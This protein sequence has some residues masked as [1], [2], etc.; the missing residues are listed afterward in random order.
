MKY[1]LLILLLI[2]PFFNVKAEEIITVSSKTTLDK[3][4]ITSS[5]SNKSSLYVTNGDLTLT[6]S[7]V[8][9]DG[10][11][12]VDGLSNK[13]NSAII[14]SPKSLFTMNKSEVETKALYAHGIYFEN[15]SENVLKSSK[16]YTNNKYSSGIVNDG[17]KVSLN[18]IDIETN[19]NDSSG[20]LL[21]R[22]NI[23]IEN[24]RITTN[25]NSSPI[26]KTASN[27]DISNSSLT[28]NNSEGFIAIADGNIKFNKTELISNNTMTSALNKSYMNI[29]I[30][31]PEEISNKQETNFEAKDSKIIS[32]NGD[33]F[34]VLNATA[35]ITL[36][37][38]EITNER[39]IFLKGQSLNYDGER[40]TGS[41]INLNLINQK[42][43][44]EIILDNNSKLT[45]KL[46]NSDYVGLI[47]NQKIAKGV[48]LIL[49]K[50]SHI[51]LTGST[52]VDS[53]TNGDY[54][55]TNIDLNGYH[56][57]IKGEELS[58][59]N[60]IHLEDSNDS[61]Y[62]YLGAFI[63]IMLGFSVVYLLKIRKSNEK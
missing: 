12:K 24:S 32:K 57:Y 14:I 43:T 52:Y 33:S 20:L 10:N 21:I 44:G 59:D 39:G 61:F 17:G 27:I 28:S 62:I 49:T 60:I 9:K 41:I 37:N 31:N 19:A 48:D 8:F 40:K 11:G 5:V 50:D 36:N 45:M 23:D 34:N 2:I 56:L 58:K 4:E 46:D 30:Y 18:D 29:L 63:G 1:K 7:K 15:E 53:L 54:D 51:K 55:N 47:N 13:D 35:N 3:K 25:A 26:F 16:I 22:G 6:N 42:V 38:T